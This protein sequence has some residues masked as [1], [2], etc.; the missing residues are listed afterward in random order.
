MKRLINIFAWLLI[1]VMFLAVVA[2]LGL[3]AMTDPLSALSFNGVA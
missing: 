3:I 1:V 2:G